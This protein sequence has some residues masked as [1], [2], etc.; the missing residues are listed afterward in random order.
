MPQLADRPT[1][2]SVCMYTVT[3][4]RHFVVDRHPRHPQVA[5]AAGLSGHGFKFVPVL[6]RILADLALDGQTDLP[7][8]FFYP[9]IDRHE[10]LTPVS[11]LLKNSTGCDVVTATTK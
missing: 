7:I 11:S 9:P 3:P 10:G 2:H 4:D 5:L 6:G 1:E 8:A